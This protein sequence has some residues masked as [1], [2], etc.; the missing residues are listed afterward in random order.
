VNLKKYNLIPSINL[1]LDVVLV[2]FENGIG[3]IQFVEDVGHPFLVRNF[4]ERKAIRNTPFLLPEDIPEYRV[5]LILGVLAVES[6]R[7]NIGSL[8]RENFVVEDIHEVLAGYACLAEFWQVIVV[9][10]D[11]VVKV[12][13]VVNRLVKLVKVHFA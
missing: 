8:H 2:D 4:Q 13:Q 7:T 12:F 11:D 9:L 3:W 1:E 10:Q 5:E 6:G